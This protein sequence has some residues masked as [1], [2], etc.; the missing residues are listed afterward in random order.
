MALARP[1]DGCLKP[2]GGWLWISGR[3]DG[4]KAQAFDCVPNISGDPLSP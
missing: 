3:H 1:F 4:F 2:G